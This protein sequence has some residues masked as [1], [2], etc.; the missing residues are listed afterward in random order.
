[1]GF[2]VHKERYSHLKDREVDATQPSAVL[3]VL[4]KHLALKDLTLST[5][6]VRKAGMWTQNEELVVPQLRR[7]S[8]YADIVQGGTHQ[9]LSRDGLTFPTSVV[10]YGSDCRE[11]LSTVVVSQ[12]CGTRNGVQTLQGAASLEVWS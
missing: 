8:G 5:S 9:S 4:A 1:M 12:E 3:V 10:L 6:R 11:S 7:R 2:E